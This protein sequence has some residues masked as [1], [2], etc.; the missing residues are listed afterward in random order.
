MSSIGSELGAWWQGR[1]LC[2]SYHLAYFGALPLQRGADLAAPQVS[3]RWALGALDAG[4][5]EVLGVLGPD[6]KMPGNDRQA[7][8]SH[9]QHAP[10]L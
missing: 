8:L 10:L 1:P 3:L 4:Q 6:L 9:A 5:F 7:R 2:R